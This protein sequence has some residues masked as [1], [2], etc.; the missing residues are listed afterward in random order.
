[1]MTMREIEYERGYHRG[2]FLP[3]LL[4]AALFLA[5]IF[6]GPGKVEISFKFVAGI[7]AGIA[8]FHGIAWWGYAKIRRDR[9]GR[10]IPGFPSEDRP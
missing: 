6:I 2:A 1:M 10:W 9:D 4:L 8:I 7:V 5:A 3:W